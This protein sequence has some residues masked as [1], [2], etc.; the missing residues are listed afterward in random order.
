MENPLSEHTS[1]EAERYTR[2]KDEWRKA[3][4]VSLAVGNGGGLAALAAWSSRLGEFTQA[5]ELFLPGMWI[6][7]AGLVFAGGMPFA[8]WWNAHALSELM[9]GHRDED[10]AERIEVK[11]SKSLSRQALMQVRSEYRKEQGKFIRP[12]IYVLRSLLAASTL[13]FITATFISLW[14]VSTSNVF[15]ATPVG[16]G[17]EA[18]QPGR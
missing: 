5:V 7:T 4:I 8:A 14:T 11:D 17:K 12:S 3:A 13:C 15:A 6:Y 9:Q 18:R 2:I 1:R 16:S 10:L